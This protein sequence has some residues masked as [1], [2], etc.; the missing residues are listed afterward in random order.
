MLYM[1]I[2]EQ[3]K[4]IEF[5]DAMRGFTM[6]LVVYVHVLMY[7]FNGI[8]T[9]S[10][11]H[12]FVLFRMPLFFFVSGFLFYKAT[13][14][15]NIHTTADILWTKF[16]VQIIP[17]LI[18]LSLNVWLWGG[19]IMDAISGSNKG[20]YWFTIT[21]F[22]YFL[23]FSFCMFVGR[24]I[25]KWLLCCFVFAF[26]LLGVSNVR[27]IIDSWGV[28]TELLSLVKLRYFVYFCLGA[29]VKEYYD[30]FIVF[31]NNQY[32]LAIT[33]VGFFLIS[34]VLYKFGLSE[35]TIRAIFAG[36]A[37]I[38]GIVIVFRFFYSNQNTFSNETGIGKFLQY[39][40]RRTLDIYLLHFFFVP[41]DLSFLYVSFVKHVNP[42]LEFLVTIIISLWVI[43]L[44]L[45]ISNVVRLSPFL[46]HWLFGV[47]NEK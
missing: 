33:I 12:A 19:N 6:V 38:L 37:G 22:L 42:C 4:R 32:V 41:R 18:F 2:I 47:K 27:N 36:I 29:I 28:N 20:G 17:T 10:Y 45:I 14:I 13:R 25:G 46:A 5:L 15:W 3:K 43:V 34:F 16:K 31:I 30:R 23:T 21:L 7:G 9:A 11:Q 8:P 39:I 1:A 35:G 40:G 44:C 24:N 26:L